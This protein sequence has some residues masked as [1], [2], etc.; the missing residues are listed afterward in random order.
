MAQ[1]SDDGSELS[2]ILS[3][4]SARTLNFCLS[5][6]LLSETRSCLARRDVEELGS[7]SFLCHDH[8]P[9]ISGT[10]SIFFHCCNVISRVYR[11]TICA[12]LHPSLQGAM[13]R[14]VAG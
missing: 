11:P 7:S 10:F 2:A 6:F 14:D 5:Q 8:A 4:M 1:D 12:E 13:K 3:H 9:I